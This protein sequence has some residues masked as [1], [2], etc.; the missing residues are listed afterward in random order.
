[1]VEG[2]PSFDK[3]ALGLQ[4]VRAADSVPANIAEATGR[5]HHRDQRRQLLVARGSLYELEHLLE[6]ANDRGLTDDDLGARVPEIARTLNGL[7]K[8]QR[9]A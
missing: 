4:I 3:W 7:I 2:W 9:E 6:A 1:M 8:R 5:W